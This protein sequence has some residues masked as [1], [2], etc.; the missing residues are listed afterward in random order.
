M[1]HRYFVDHNLS[2]RIAE[3][4]SGLFD[5]D[6]VALVDR[7]DP[8]APH[9]EWLEALDGRVVVTE[10]VEIRKK[11][12]YRRLLS[13]K[14]SRP[15]PAAH[16]IAPCGESLPNAAPRRG[17]RAPSPARPRRWRTLPAR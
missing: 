2:H 4:I 7:F 10:D 9:E 12:V 13:E 16:R 14:V 17:R 1:K 5:A 3:A 8:D 15:A 11:D 6:V